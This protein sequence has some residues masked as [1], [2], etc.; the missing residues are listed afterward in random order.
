M[1]V[2][3]E[4]LEWLN[5]SIH[6][7]LNQSYQDFELIAVVDNP[8]NHEAVNF[9]SD[10]K[11]TDKRLHLIL[12]EQN[13]GLTKSLNKALKV[14]KGKYI[15]RMDADDISHPL[16][17]EKQ[18]AYM[19]QH[20]DI[21]ILNTYATLFGENISSKLKTAPIEHEAIAEIL[22][23]QCVIVHPA[24]MIRC[25]SF[26][27]AYDESFRRSQDYE[28]WLRLLYDGARFH[29][30]PESL[31]E[32]RISQTQISTKNIG[33][34]LKDNFRARKKILDS[35]FCDYGYKG[36]T[37]LSLSQ[38]KE[39]FKKMQSVKYESLERTAIFH[40]YYSLPHH[41]WNFFRIPYD[42]FQYDFSIK[43]TTCIMLS[44]FT[45]RWD[46][47]HIKNFPENYHV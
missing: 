38:I 47:Y 24:V 2:Y 25:V 9:L 26:K 44:Y 12:N 16:R 21:D 34:Q 35:I 32:Y 10:L 43:Q 23:Y 22:P 27:I 6:S 20:E 33:Q 29:T 18:I 11:R 5:I 31:L 15:A 39:L 28:L 7:I 30:L 13:I 8:E 17:L 40:T 37:V 3:N 46:N 42:A 14:A 4:P 19:E 1:S 45:H 41:F 36:L